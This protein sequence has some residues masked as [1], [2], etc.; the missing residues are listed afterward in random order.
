MISDKQVM[1]GD[2]LENG[3]VDCSLMEP[4]KHLMKQDWDAEVDGQSFRVCL[5]V[6]SMWRIKPKIGSDLPRTGVFCFAG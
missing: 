4:G 5:L 2:W 6:P 3:L 1:N